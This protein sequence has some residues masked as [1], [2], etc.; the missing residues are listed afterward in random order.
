MDVEQSELSYIVG[1]S[2]GLYSCSENQSAI[3]YKAMHTLSFE[4]E[5]QFLGL[6]RNENLYKGIHS[7]F[8]KYLLC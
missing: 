7:N 4:P 3:S 2:I 8:I 5:I 6:K 1:R